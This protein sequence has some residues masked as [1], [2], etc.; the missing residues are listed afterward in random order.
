MEGFFL[1]VCVFVCFC[2]LG[3]FLSG[4]SLVFCFL[5]FYD[6]FF[7][8]CVCLLFFLFVCLVLLLPFVWGFVCLFLIVVADV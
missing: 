3:F 4:C 5:C 7:C 1:F 2:F 6:C 8:M